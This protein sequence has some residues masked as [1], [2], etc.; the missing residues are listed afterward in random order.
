[1]K[2]ALHKIFNCIEE[3][4][5][6]RSKLFTDRTPKSILK[7]L[8]HPT[9]YIYFIAARKEIVSFLIA[10]F[11]RRLIIVSLSFFF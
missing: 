6:A 5:A 4:L 8:I 9:R 3:P 7:T 11:M 2:T 1:M 10:L